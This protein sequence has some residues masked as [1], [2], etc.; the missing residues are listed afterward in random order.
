MVWELF[1]DMI[2]RTDLTL[3]RTYRVFSSADM[4]PEENTADNFHS[5]NPTRVADLTPNLGIQA[6][7]NATAST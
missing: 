4:F 7:I 6:A 5:D 1:C 3:P 2:N